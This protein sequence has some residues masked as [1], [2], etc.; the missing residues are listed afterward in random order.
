MT[1]RTIYSNYNYLNFNCTY[2][3]LKRLNLPITFTHPLKD[4]FDRLDS[5][6]EF[7]KRLF[8]NSLIKISYNLIKFLKSKEDAYETILTLC[9][10]YEN[11]CKEKYP[12]APLPLEISDTK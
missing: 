11:L 3:K 6:L 5:D 8:S 7:K 2:F 12:E 4:I 9:K 1:K 10:K